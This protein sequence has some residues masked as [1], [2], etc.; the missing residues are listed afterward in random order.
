[1]GIYAMARAKNRSYDDCK[2]RSTVQGKSP[3]S[4]EMIDLQYYVGEK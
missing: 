1:M 4:G 2:L 3:K